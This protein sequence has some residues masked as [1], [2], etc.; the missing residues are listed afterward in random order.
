VKR[1][2]K[3]APRLDQSGRQGKPRAEQDQIAEDGAAA[4]RLM[5]ERTPALILLDLLMPTMDGFE[6]AW[7]VRRDARWRS[8]PI[9]VST[10]KDLGPEDRAR[11]AGHVESV[12][13]KGAY[14]PEELL[15]QIRELA[16]RK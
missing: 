7:A 16:A 4:L 14:T 9:I 1:C 11:L 8:I 5:E 2:G 15:R 13:A 10:S 12:L 3:S 6:F